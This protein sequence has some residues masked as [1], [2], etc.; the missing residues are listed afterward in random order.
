MPQLDALRA[1]AV[2]SVAW[3][4]WMPANYHFN[5]PFGIAGVQLFFVLSG[6]L[7][8]GILLRCRSDDDTEKPDAKPTDRFFAMRSFYARRFLRIFPLYYGVL[9]IALIAN[10]ANMR[11]E[12]GWHAA[13]LSNFYFYIQGAFTWPIGHFWSLAVE[14][15][16]YLVWPWAIVF[17]PYRWL[18]PLIVALIAIA[19]LFRMAGIFFATASQQKFVGTLPIGSL[20]ALGA[21]ALLA[22][23]GVS[24]SAGKQFAKVGLLVCLPLWIVLQIG[25]DLQGEVLGPIQQTVMIL[26]F[27]WLIAKTAI[28]FE[29]WAGQLLTNPSLIYLGKISYGLY[30]LHNLAPIPLAAVVDWLRLPAGI[31]NHLFFRLLPLSIGTVAGASLS[32][33]LYEKPLNDLKKYFPYKPRQIVKANE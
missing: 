19:P 2:I 28:G 11:S 3:A 26:F 23:F 1:L 31:Y 18:K 8:T 21:G 7:I 14:E 10:I 9:V 27:V 25:H 20:D 12:W 24:S 29:G 6:Y 5:L 4:H 33:F 22:L 30:V 15:Q 32:W 17:L 13:Y 16:F